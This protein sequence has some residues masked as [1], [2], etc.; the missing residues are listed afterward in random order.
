MTPLLPTPGAGF[1]EPFALLSACHERVQRSLALLQ[2]LQA[3][4]A[5]HGADAQARDAARDVMRYFDI[6]APLHHEDEERHVFPA[7][8][9][10]DPARHGPLVARLQDDHRR[11]AAAWPAARAALQA[12]ADG[13]WSAADPAAAARD[14][15][16]FAA[17]YGPHI[18]AEE[19]SAYPVVQA[20]ADAAATAAM[21][22]EMAA[23]RGLTA[24]K[25]GR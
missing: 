3:H 7:L 1:D 15:S 9:A 8:L 2:R 5:V 16:H 14:W 23:R 21:G 17:L 22:A 12:V 4:L 24:V 6:A 10:A 20:R 13:T 18:D 19:R 11:M 25:P